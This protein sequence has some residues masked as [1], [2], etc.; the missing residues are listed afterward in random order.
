MANDARGTE[1]GIRKDQAGPRETRDE[2][3]EEIRSSDSQPIIRQPNRDRARGDWDRTGD[4][5]DVGASR[6][7]RNDDE[8]AFDE[9]S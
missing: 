2:V 4:H 1:K 9:R 5:T 8:E 3:L 7:P 6:S